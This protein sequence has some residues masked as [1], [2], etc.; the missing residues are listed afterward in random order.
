MNGLGLAQMQLG[1]VREAR[2]ALRE[3]EMLA[4]AAG[5]KRM[6]AAA[7]ANQA[8]LA[9]RAGEMGEVELWL[10]EAIRLDRET[11]NLPGL[12]H[13]LALLARARQQRG[14]ASDARE[15]Y[16]QA[17]TIAGHTGQQG[18]THPTDR[19]SGLAEHESGVRLQRGQVKSIERDHRS[20]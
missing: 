2:Q 10:D 3:A 19:A 20:E 7:L 5:D 9:L 16:R 15:L 6:L 1:Q 12:A 4:R 13:D 11:E 17:R 8:G 14:D 18:Q